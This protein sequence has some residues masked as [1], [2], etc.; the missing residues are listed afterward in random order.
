MN[1]LLRSDRGWRDWRFRPAWPL[2]GIALLMPVSAALNWNAVVAAGFPSSVA[3]VAGSIACMALVS[4]MA[5]R[6]TKVPLGSVPRAVMVSAVL[7]FGVLTAALLVTRSYFSESYV[8]I[9]F[10]WTIAW[11]SA[12][13]WLR[14]RLIGPPKWGLA[15][16]GCV[17]P[18]HEVE[19]VVWV[20]L[21]EVPDQVAGFGAIVADMRRPHSEA[22][23]RFLT[24][25]R[26]AR[27]PVLDASAVY[28]AATGRVRSEW[29]SE[30][31]LLS[32]CGARRRFS[33]KLALDYL[34]TLLVAPLAVI[35]VLG[36][37][38]AI[39]LDDGGPIFFTQRRV[40]LGGRTFRIFKLRTMTG[41]GPA[42][43]AHIG[44]TPTRI[45]RFLRRFRLD[46]LP[47]LLN[48]LRGEM[49]IVGPRPEQR[50]IVDTYT[51]EIP[52]YG[53][54]H[55]VRPGLTGWS[56]VHYGYAADAQESSEKLEYDLYYI[57][58]RSFLLD[59]TILIRSIG[60]VVTGRGA[61]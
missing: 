10:G 26:L 31:E 18:L 47:Q 11:V 29:V 46:E 52:A 13:L 44:G 58:H 35:L 48:V 54:R 53:V 4:L 50:A 21:P 43:A 9:A 8:L 2:A 1:T 23:S 55:I 6:A 57:K 59:F 15:A 56:Q 34:C 61:L 51:A 19:R 16:V 22:W 28:E 5:S 25:C 37:A 40:G 39:K 36:S 30:S 12:G 14:S 24:D 38:V 20:D 60:V 3:M 45:G 42:D 41:E 17:E 33:L 27:V 32:A 7:S 49:S